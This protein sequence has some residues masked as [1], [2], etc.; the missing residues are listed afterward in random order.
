MEVGS[1]LPGG[2]VSAGFAGVS[3]GLMVSQV[4]FGN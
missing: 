2:A 4:R 3:D 1:S